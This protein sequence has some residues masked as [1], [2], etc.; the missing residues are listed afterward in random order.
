LGTLLAETGRA[1][2]AIAQFEKAIELQPDY[3][4]ARTGL[5]SALSKLGKLDEALAELRRAIASDA[6]YAPAHYELGVT[7]AQRGDAA[8]AVAEWRAAIESDPKHAEAHARL[9]DAL[10]AHGRTAE[11]LTHWRAAIDLRPNDADTLRRAA[12]TLATSPDAALRNGTES[13]QHA[14]RAMELTGGRDARVLD[15]LAAAYAEKGQFADAV[16]TAR[17]A[18]SRASAENQPALADE[19]KLRVAL[20]EEGKPFRERD[21]AG[22]QP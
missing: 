18:E 19:I 2:E 9:A 20:Y 11:A 14:V 12:W 21:A 16:L 10:A 4:A 5:A 17:R 6:R 1:E 15:T 3:A 7:L 22:A 8:A 13:L